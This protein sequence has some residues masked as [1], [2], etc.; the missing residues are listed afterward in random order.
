MIIEENTRFFFRHIEKNAKTA[1]MGRI[2]SDLFYI[3]IY[4][5]EKRPS[6]E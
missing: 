4:S 6:Y 2:G 1:V 3:Y 5:G